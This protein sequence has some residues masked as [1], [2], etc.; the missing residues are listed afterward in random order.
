MLVCGVYSF[1]GAFRL[2]LFRLIFG[3][4]RG[5]FWR[6]FWDGGGDIFRAFFEEH[7]KFCLQPAREIL[8]RSWV[9]NLNLESSEYPCREVSI[10]TGCQASDQGGA[11]MLIV[12]S[13]PDNFL[14]IGKTKIEPQHF[15]NK[16]I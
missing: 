5:T 11:A 13:D 2:L 10:D 8:L 4:F 16:S 15:L 9:E 1:T 7:F 12:F 6:S 3:D 14:A